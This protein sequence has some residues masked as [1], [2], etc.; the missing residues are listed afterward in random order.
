L[1]A[2]LGLAFHRHLDQRLAI[3]RELERLA[4][5]GIL[6]ERVLLRQV[7][8]GDVD[9]DALVA[10]LDDLGDAEAAVA[11]QLRHVGGREALDEV[12]LA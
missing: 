8:L 6:A 2:G 3:N 1:V 7:A 9:G 10:Q 11:P 12:E 4:H 5:P